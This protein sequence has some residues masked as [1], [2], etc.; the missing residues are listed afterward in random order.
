VRVRAAR[1]EAGARW[2][3]FVDGRYNN[4]STDP[5]GALALNVKPGRHWLSVDLM[6]GGRHSR[7]SRPVGIKVARSGDPVLAAAGDIACDPQSA[8][9]NGGRGTVDR[10]HAAATARLVAGAQPSLVLPLGDLQYQCGTAAAFSAS[11]AL[12]WGRFASISRP[13]PGNHEY[14]TEGEVPLPGCVD[15]QPGQGYFSYW[16]PYLSSWSAV[17][18]DQPDYYSYDV[19]SW[20][21]IALNSECDAL[22]GCGVGSPQEQWLAA[23]LAAHPSSCTLAYLH[24]PRWWE[25]PGGQ[26]PDLDALWRDL[27][28][29]DTDLVLAGHHHVYARFT[30]LDADGNQSR[31]G[32]QQIIVGTGGASLTRISKWA[33]TVRAHSDNSYGILV[34]TLHEH[35]YEW[36]FMPEQGGTFTDYG[37]SACH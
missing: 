22:G 31:P 14:G 11:Y 19:G 18:G 29:A 25:T 30:P 13:I 3:V 26:H 15:A 17:A 2:R 8:D 12:T 10:C 9:F 23:D 24:Q 6:F 27:A 35:G 4:F 7:R 34:L 20:H 28:A 21:V 37:R 5:T 1:W 32:I 36:Q 16:G 33:P